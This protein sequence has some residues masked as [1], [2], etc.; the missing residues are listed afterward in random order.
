[1]RMARG[2]PRGATSLRPCAVRHRCLRA[3]LW[4]LRLRSDIEQVPNWIDVM[5]IAPFYVDLVIMQV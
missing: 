1:M 3:Q 2:A 5:A 4:P